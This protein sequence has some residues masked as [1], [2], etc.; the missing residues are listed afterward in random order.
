MFFIKFFT[1]ILSYCFIE[2]ICFFSVEIERTDIKNDE[3]VVLIVA[4]VL[5]NF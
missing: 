1:S 5:V 4:P 3:H 2:I